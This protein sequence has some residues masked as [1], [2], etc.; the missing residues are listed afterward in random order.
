MEAQGSTSLGADPVDA[1][2]KRGVQHYQ[3]EDNVRSVEDAVEY[4]RKIVG[5]EQGV[6]DAEIVTSSYENC[7]TSK[8][9]R[10]SFTKTVRELK[11][12]TGSVAKT[13]KEVVSAGSVTETLEGVASAGSVAETPEEVAWAGRLLLKH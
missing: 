9:K 7:V 1:I 6:F 10:V 4:V 12:S 13:P 2:Q 5:Y 3:G 8:Q 11:K